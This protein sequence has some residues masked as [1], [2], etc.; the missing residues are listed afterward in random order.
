LTV[1]GSDCADVGLDAGEMLTD[2]KGPLL[3]ASS[4]PEQSRDVL[5]NI[6]PHIPDVRRDLV[7]IH[8]QWVAAAYPA[9]FPTVK[10]LDAMVAALDRLTTA[11]KT[12][13]LEGLPRIYQDLNSA[14][15]Q[16]DFDSA[17]LCV[18]R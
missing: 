12:K 17:D 18:E 3:A 4:Q 1:P 11:A 9:S 6:V 8:K 5:P 7:K 14:L 2:M 13:N 15:A 10:D 16:Y